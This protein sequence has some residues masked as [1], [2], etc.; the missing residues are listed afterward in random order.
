MSWKQSRHLL[1]HYML[2]GFLTISTKMSLFW[3]HFRQWLA[4]IIDEKFVKIVTFPFEYGGPTWSAH[5]YQ[6][7][8]MVSPIHPGQGRS[9]VTGSLTRCMASSRGSPQG[10]VELVGIARKYSYC[11]ASRPP[12]SIK[13]ATL[14]GYMRKY[15]REHSS[16]LWGV[17]TGHHWIPPTKGRKRFHVDVV[18]WIR[19]VHVTWSSAPIPLWSV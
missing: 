2:P 9:P 12:T 11:K 19:G 8:L 1:L 17:F 6:I 7:E 13:P 3:W 10:G 4:P 18:M 5:Q 15:M 16:Q 14:V